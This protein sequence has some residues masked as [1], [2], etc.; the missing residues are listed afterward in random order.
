MPNDRFAQEIRK[1]GFELEYRVSESFRRHGWTVITNKYYVDDLQETV[2]EIDLVAYRTGKV[3][4]FRVVTTIIVSCKKNSRDA[5]VLLAKQIDPNDPNV[6]WRPLHAWASDRALQHVIGTPEWRDEF[7]A[8]AARYQ[9]GDLNE[10]PEQHLFAFQEMNKETGK[11]NDDKNIF[12]AVTSLMKAQAYELG[13]LPLRLRVPAVYQFNLMSVV[14]A[15]MV[16][17][18]FA[19]DGAILAVPTTEEPYVARYIIA[20][21]QTFSRIHFVHAQVLD[22]VLAKYDRLHQSN[23]SF[24]DTACTRF[25]AD[26]VQVPAKIGAFLKEIQEGLHVRISWRLADMGCADFS[27]QAIGL[28]WDTEAREVQALLPLPEEAVESLN[29]QPSLRRSLASLLEAHY[30]YRGPSRFVVDDVPF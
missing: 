12:A 9:C 15:D 18:D 27:P 28:S 14:D 22:Q 30:R 4:H 11:P 20:K 17:L 13:A 23:L 21:Q 10:V 24:F 7:I 25:Y 1:T 29:G 26:A 5:W 2:R 19:P 6:D 3:Q 8:H 16:R